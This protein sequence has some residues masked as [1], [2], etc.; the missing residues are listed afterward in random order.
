M[1]NAH[2]IFAFSPELG[3]KDFSSHSFYPG[4]NS[5][6]KIITED[7]KVVKGFLKMHIPR[8]TVKSE[9]SS[10]SPESYYIQLTDGEKEALAKSILSKSVHGMTEY[11]LTLYQHGLSNLDN[12]RLLFLH[13]GNKVRKMKILVS[14]KDSLKKGKEVKIQ[15]LKNG[16]ITEEI[17]IRR[18]S[19]VKFNFSNKLGSNN[20]FVMLIEKDNNLVGAF[21]HV[22]EPKSVIELL[23]KKAQIV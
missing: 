16:F 9:I 17:S 7:Y 14:R 23:S 21:I 3:D 13:K 6:K 10:L 12:V 4:K 15:H 18:R 20:E 1:L 11:Q 8:F 19:F 5:Q 22:L 2:N